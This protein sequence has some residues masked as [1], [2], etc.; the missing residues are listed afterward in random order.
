M[1]PS[2]SAM[3][4]IAFLLFT[5]ARLQ[6]NACAM[7]YDSYVGTRKS[8]RKSTKSAEKSGNQREIRKSGTGNHWQNGEIGKSR[9]GPLDLELKL[10]YKCTCSVCKQ[11]ACRVDVHFSMYMYMYMKS[12]SYLRRSIV[13]AACNIAG[14]LHQYDQKIKNCD[15]YYSYL[16]L[17]S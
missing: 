6:H 13:F 15:Y 7:S 11:T 1:S 5:Y 9:V 14:Y 2:E 8:T 10:T 3:P 16:D 12:P 17:S 4:L